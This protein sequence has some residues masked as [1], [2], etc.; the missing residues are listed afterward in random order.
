[1]KVV[2]SSTVNIEKSVNIEQSST[3]MIKVQQ[4]EQIVEESKEKKSSKKDKKSK[5]DKDKKKKSKKKRSSSSSSSSSIEEEVRSDRSPVD[6]GETQQSF[7]FGPGVSFAQDS[8]KI[9]ARTDLPNNE[10]LQAAQN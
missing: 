7:N 10:A 3:T 2:E 4:S 8:F 1:M 5:K 9:S 6:V